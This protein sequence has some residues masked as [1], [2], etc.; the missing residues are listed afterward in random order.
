MTVLRSVGWD[1]S[2]RNLYIWLFMPFVATSPRRRQTFK[3]TKSTLIV[4][5]LNSFFFLFLQPLLGT[6][7]IQGLQSRIPQARGFPFS[8]SVT[9]QFFLFSFLGTFCSLGTASTFGTQ[10]KRQH[11]YV[12]KFQTNP[13]LL[14]CQGRA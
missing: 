10:G 6:N 12:R 4:Y 8:T 3:N 9:S 1:G 14:G 5:F 11:H 7:L 2:P 13:S